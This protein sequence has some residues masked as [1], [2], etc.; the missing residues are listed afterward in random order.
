[1]L[2]FLEGW[3]TVRLQCDHVRPLL[4]S[5]QCS[6]LQCNCSSAKEKDMGPCPLGG[7]PHHGLQT[8][9]NAWFQLR[10]AKL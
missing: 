4:W 9:W 5:S 2:M 7:G 6:Q 1:M 8:S 10:H 3:V